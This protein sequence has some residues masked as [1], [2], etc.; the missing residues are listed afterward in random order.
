MDVNKMN[1][2]DLSMCKSDK[3]DEELLKLPNRISETFVGHN[4]FV[5]GGTGFMG[6][7]FV[8]KVLRKTPD[9]GGIYLL[10]RNKKGKDPKERLKDVFANPLFNQV[11][12][13][14][15]KDILERKVHPILGDVTLPDLGVS[16]ADRQFLAE[17]ITIV[18]HMA[19]TIR[20]DE[21]LKKAVMLNT[22]GTKL[23]LQLAKE[24]KKL[25]FFA[26]ISTAY[27]HLNEPVLYEKPYPPPADPHNII[28]CMEWMTDEVAESMTKKILGNLPNTY[29]YTKALAEHLVV[30]Q[31]DSLPI[32][33][34]RPSIVVPIWKE[35]LPGWTD[36]INGP[37]GLLIGAGKGV[38]RSMYCDSDTYAD[39]LPVDIAVNG[40]MVA[41]WNYIKLGDR[42]RR[43]CHMT[44]SSEIKLSWSEIVELGRGIVEN[45]VP[46]NGVA[47]YPGGSLKRSRTYHR[48]CVFFFHWVPAYIL[49]V[50]IWLS[51][52]EP[53]LKRVQNRIEKGFEVFEY[54][55][56]N[57]W[58]FKNESAIYV[59]PL[60]NAR[61]RREYKVDGDGIDF[62]QYFT[63]CVK[64]A[65][66]YI[67][68]E[69]P[70]TIPAARRHMRVMYFV[71]WIAHILFW[72]FV[73][74][75]LTLC[76]STVHDAREQVF[77]LVGGGFRSILG[78]SDSVAAST[79]AP[80]A[81]VPMSDF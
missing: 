19:A 13:E 75:L 26:H 70:E 14:H 4:I 40:M 18:Y 54:Y 36:N 9:V 23:I 41:T 57:Q 6:K 28:K 25:Q 47:W 74:Y 50:F 66:V 15:G 29:A 8:E 21:K 39:F 34:M 64:A 49:D 60:M 5:T 20:F 48:I 78:S 61:E 30:E 16:P 59:R 53:V 68:N 51:G 12:E 27:C 11:K 81:P 45:V 7:V 52:N 37:T 31:M 38:I 43:V 76:S 1:N 72:Y 77:G 35:P 69:P 80:A 73:V 2:N 22:R 56:N 58:D 62:Q 3:L 33:I 55:A 71:D 10:I 65:R 63:D 46:L 42:N 67:L 32:V 17:N 24:M 44:S 79:G